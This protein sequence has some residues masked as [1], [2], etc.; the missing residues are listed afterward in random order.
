MEPTFRELFDEHA[1]A[2]LVISFSYV[3]DWGTAEDIVQEVFL[4]HWQKREQ[5]QQKSSLKTYL[6]RV[7]IN[8]S[9]DYLKSWRYRTQ[10]LTNQFFV[11][12]KQKQALLIEEEQNVIGQAVLS[13]P[14][15]LRELVLLY[16]YESFTYRDI[17]TM[18][19]IAESTVRSRL[20]KAKSLLKNQLPNEPWEVL[21]D[22]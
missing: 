16:Y 9:K 10:Q 14:I 20:N 6:T 5:F 7:C 12:T 3:K 13:L 8:R 19:S 2:L 11:T 17:A 21:L 22:D 15:E 1:D 4:K 18:L